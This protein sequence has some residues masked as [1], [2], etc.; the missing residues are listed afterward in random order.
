MCGLLG[1]A[2][3]YLVAREKTIFSQLL[4]A[5]VFRGIHSTGV[6]M[7]SRDVGAG[8]IYNYQMYKKAIPSAALL[9]SKDYINWRDEHLNPAKATCKVLMGHNRKATMGNIDDASAHPFIEGNIIL[10]HNGTLHQMDNLD[11]HEYFEIDSQCIAH[12]VNKNGIEETVGRLDGAFALSWINK[13]ENT[14]N[15]IRN[16]Q[17]PLCLVTSKSGDI[18]WASEDMMLKWVLDR[19][20]ARFDTSWDV[21]PGQHF[22]FDL[23]KYSSNFSKWE[24][25]DYKLYKPKAYPKN[26]GYGN[27]HDNYDDTFNRHEIQQ[28]RLVQFPLYQREEARLKRLAKKDKRELIKEELQKQRDQKENKGNNNGGGTQRG[29][30]FQENLGKYNLEIGQEIHF[31]AYNWEPYKTNTVG[32]HKGVLMGCMDEDPWIL[33][34]INGVDGSKFEANKEYITRAINVNDIGD[35]PHVVGTILL[36]SSGKVDLLKSDK[37]ETTE[38]GEKEKEAEG[39]DAEFASVQLTIEEVDEEMVAMEK[40]EEDKLDYEYVNGSGA[41]ISKKTMDYLTRQ[42]CC[43][44]CGDIE[45]EDYD[46][47]HWADNGLPI[48]GVCYEDWVDVFPNISNCNS[49]K[50]PRH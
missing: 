11:D 5:G 32:N 38:S 7:V 17:R 20:N 35:Y 27:Y 29:S 22:K 47:V 13:E 34:E 40:E 28:N 41:F 45:E 37:V 15:F 18:I 48:C 26:N 25:A 23:T 16:N 21:K 46:A 8:D 12:N 4:Y 39:S 14:L 42:G 31:S 43:H 44:C 36:D 33:V 6:A 9:S 24:V 3:P 2:N 49:A 1:I 10:A 19:N 50:L 30:R